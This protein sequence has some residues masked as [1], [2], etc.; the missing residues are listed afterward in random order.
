MW[1]PQRLEARKLTGAG[2]GGE[3]LAIRRAGY[4]Q[5]STLK[6]DEAS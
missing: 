6:E 4:C 3:G 2:G 5:L 1:A